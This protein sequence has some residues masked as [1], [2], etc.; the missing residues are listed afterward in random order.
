MIPVTDYSAEK[1]KWD[2][3]RKSLDAINVD[4]NTAT[5]L[6]GDPTGEE[7][8]LLRT[9]LGRL[10][11]CMS[12]EHFGRLAWQFKRVSGSS[13]FKVQAAIAC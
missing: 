11:R 2:K 4:A 12:S 9:E 3:V 6:N 10:G 13:G 1:A 7:R 5:V 8:V